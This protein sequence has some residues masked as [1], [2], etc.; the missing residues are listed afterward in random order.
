MLLLAIETSSVRG[1]LALFG[2][3]EMIR[4]CTFDEGLVHGRELTARLEEALALE[5][6]KAPAL[7]AIAV[8]VG[9]GSY[10]G[11]RVGVA[12]A[13]ALAFALSIPVVARSSLE[14][15]AMNALEPAASG[16]EDTARVASLVNARQEI[17]FGALFALAPAAGLARLFPDQALP[18]RAL[19]A[20][21]DLALPGAPGP[22]LVL[23]DGADIFLAQAGEQPGIPPLVRLPAPLDTPRARALGVLASPAAAAARFDREAIHALDP[24]YLRVTEAERRLTARTAAASGSTAGG[25]AT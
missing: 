10:T 7:D 24:A 22:L 17:L 15:L 14:V 5:G 8:S 20:G 4:E 12:A 3:G 18:P 6:L 23:G 21:W 25:P 11:I 13:K 1:S 16:R 2:D 9:P 19:A